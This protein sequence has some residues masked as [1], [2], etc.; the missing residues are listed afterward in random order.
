V[1]EVRAR[2]WWDTEKTAATAD[3]MVGVALV[4]DGGA[5]PDYNFVRYDQFLILSEKRTCVLLVF[6]KSFFGET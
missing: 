5:L 2:E 4:M 3:T 6:G 1:V